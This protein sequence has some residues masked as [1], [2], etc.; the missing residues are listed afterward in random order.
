MLIPLSIPII[1]SIR[2]YLLDEFDL[3]LKNKHQSVFLHTFITSISYSI[4]IFLFIIEYRKTKPRNGTKQEK[5]FKN[6]LLIEKEKMEKK[7]NTYKKLYLVLLPLF[8]FFNLISYDILTILKP[9]NYNKNYYYNLSVPVFFLLTAIMSYQFLNIHIHRHQ[10]TA[11][12]I[13]LL[14][15]LSLFFILII[16]GENINKSF[17]AILFLIEIV[18]IRSLR[19]VLAVLGKLFMSKM[20]S[21]HIELMTFLGLFGILFSLITNA[22]FLFI[23][24]NFIKNPELNEY[25]YIDNN[26]GFKRFQTIFDSW[27]RFGD[28]I[29]YLIGTIICFFFEKYMSWF[30]INKFSPNHYTMYSSINSLWIIFWEICGNFFENEKYTFGNVLIFVFS[31][32][33]FIIIIV[34]SLIFNEILII[35]LF[36]LDKYTNVEINKRQKYETKITLTNQGNTSPR[37]SNNP[38]NTYD[39]EE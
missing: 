7:Q 12:I 4:N 15:S 20:Y 27:G 10:I 32:S 39:S 21:T 16:Y 9:N 6:Q 5:E 23:N 1:Y 25:F 29:L 28:S 33:V 26:S 22:I 18:G 34:C 30:C 19:Y 38:N 24:M 11:M 36:H 31:L 8:L 3:R 13:S 37:I 14:F 2:H 17:Y 35:K